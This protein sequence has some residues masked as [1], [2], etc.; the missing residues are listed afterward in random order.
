MVLVPS[1]N[2][3]F[4]LLIN[5][6]TSKLRGRIYFSSLYISQNI[7]ELKAW[8]KQNKIYFT[9]SSIKTYQD[10]SFRLIFEAPQS[11]Y[12]KLKK[13]NVTTTR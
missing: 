10:G 6:K 5:P 8:I 1:D 11:E 12:E 4:Q 2:P 7:D 9:Q 3:E 13:W